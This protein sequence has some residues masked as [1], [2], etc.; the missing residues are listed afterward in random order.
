MFLFVN[1][2]NELRDMRRVASQKCLHINI[3]GFQNTYIYFLKTLGYRQV[4]R[5]RNLNIS[6]C[7]FQMLKQ[8]TLTPQYIGSNPIILVWCERL[9][10][11]TPIRYY[12]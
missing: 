9:R 7:I 4:A 5:Q 10:L 8:R 3:N 6:F 12:S 11:F 1:L 2:Y